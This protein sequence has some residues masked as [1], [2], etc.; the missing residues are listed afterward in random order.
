MPSQSM[1]VTPLMIEHVSLSVG[2][3][4]ARRWAPRVARVSPERPWCTRSRQSVAVT[5]AVQAAWPAGERNPRTSRTNSA[6]LTFPREAKGVSACFRR[7]TAYTTRETGEQTRHFRAVTPAE[8]K[9]E[10][11]DQLPGL[12][13]QTDGQELAAECSRGVVL[14][15]AGD[16]DAQRTAPAEVPGDRA[17]WDPFRQWMLI[18]PEDEDDGHDKGAEHAQ[19]RNDVRIARCLLHVVENMERDNRTEEDLKPAASERG[20]YR[21]PRLCLRVRLGRTGSCEPGDVPKSVL[22]HDS[23][24]LAGRRGDG[25]SAGDR[26]S[27]AAGQAFGRSGVDLKRRRRRTAE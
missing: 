22:R 9:D 27:R 19:G 3:A 1:R 18:A 12:V 25:T 20:A 23:S 6:R 24:R 13:D 2:S 8:G 17:W 15:H 4:T 26:A 16:N 7:C 5:K 14:Q 11:D 10:R 21:L